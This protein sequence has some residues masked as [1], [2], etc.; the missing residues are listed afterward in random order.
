MG[1]ID[2]NNKEDFGEIFSSKNGLKDKE[3]QQKLYKAFSHY[4]HLRYFNEG[5]SIFQLDDTSDEAYFIEEGFVKLF[6]ITSDGKE[7]TLG[8][9]SS[10]ECF[11]IIEA[12]L[13]C[14]RVRYAETI[15]KKT[16]LWV[17]KKNKLNNLIANDKDILYSFYF[18]VAKHSARY[19]NIIS[20][21]ALLPLQKKVVKLLLRLS[22]EHGRKEENTIIIDCPLT[23]EELAKMIGSSRQRVSS[24]LS[25]LQKQDILICKY[26]KIIILNIKDL[27]ESSLD[28]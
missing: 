25:D 18:Q 21:L 22:E 3:I 23:H 5:E 13:H 6:T 26:K 8:V 24:I 11:G 12:I 10:G 14:P 4:G 27:I 7:I 16:A 20:E 15:Y 1:L 17:M 9:R 28:P 2:L 19:Q